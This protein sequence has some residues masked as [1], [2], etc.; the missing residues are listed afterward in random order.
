M[1][2]CLINFSHD[3]HYIRKL[4]DVNCA[5]RV[6]ELLKEIVKPD[7]EASTKTSAKFNDDDKVYEI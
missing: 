7:M 3:E 2:E 5:G 4:V 1:T 6:F